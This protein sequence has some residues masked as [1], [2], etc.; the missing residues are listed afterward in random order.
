M[1]NEAIPWKDKPKATTDGEPPEDGNWDGPAPKPVREDGQHGAYYVLPE[2]ER[3][4][5]F[6]RPYRTSYKHVGPK[7]PGELR[8]LTPEEE[9]RHAKYNYVKFEEYSNTESSLTGRYWTQAQLDSIGGCGVITKMGRKIAET[10]ARDFSYYGATFCVG[11]SSHLPV[12]TKEAG[13][14]FVWS[15]TNEYVGT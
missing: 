2:S 14:E 12:G 4:K 9:L 10:Y 3:A 13:G 7:P 1:T 8:N 6:V 5:G 11:C 15:G